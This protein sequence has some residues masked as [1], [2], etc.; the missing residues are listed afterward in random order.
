MKACASGMIESLITLREIS[1][2]FAAKNAIR[3]PIVKNEL[4][5]F[6]NFYSLL[7]ILFIF[8]LQSFQNFQKPLAW[9]FQGSL[10]ILA[11]L[12]SQI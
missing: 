2:G 4:K 12:Q 5:I 11:D 9:C 7:F 1:N 3:I 10:H 6:H 8:S